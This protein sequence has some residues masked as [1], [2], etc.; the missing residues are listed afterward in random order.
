MSPTG[1]KVLVSKEIRDDLNRYE[2]TFI[3]VTFLLH[4]LTE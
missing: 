1:E 3:I 4:N 2:S